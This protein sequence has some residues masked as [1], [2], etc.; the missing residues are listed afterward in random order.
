M[1]IRI[2]A[3]VLSAS[4]L[5]IGSAS[6]QAYG[7]NV[8][9]GAIVGGLIGAAI[10][11]ADGHHNGLGGALIGATAGALLS[12][13]QPAYYQPAYGRP[14]VYA[15]PA[16]GV[17]V[18]GQFAYLSPRPAVYGSVGYYGPAVSGYASYGGYSGAYVN[19]HRH[20]RRRR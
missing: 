13:S 18:G 2:L 14:V 16:P 3:A 6:A 5:G 11:S 19:V 9:N 4:I 20:V 1:K 10:G 17:Y 15:A 8:A 12:A 7:P